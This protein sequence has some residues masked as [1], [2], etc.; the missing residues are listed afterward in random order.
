MDKAAH[1]F[2][3]LAGI[4][5]VLGAYAIWGFIAYVAI[6][7][8]GI[9]GNAFGRL[10]PAGVVP[11][12]LL[13]LVLAISV[14]LAAGT[15]RRQIAASRRLTHRIQASTL[16]P[17]PEL[18]A[19]AEPT[20]LLGRVA[21]VDAGKPFSF[22]YGVLVPRVAISRG[23]LEI[24]STQELRATL[25]HE[26]YHVRNLDPF[27]ALT[28]RVL[29]EAFF[30]LPS[31]KALRARYEVA[32]ELAA[33]RCAEQGCGRRPLLGALLKA[34]EGPR[35]HESAVSASLGSS[36]LLAARL[37]HL[38][39][40]RMP[41]LPPVSYLSLAWSTL[42]A[43]A[44]LAV[45]LSAMIGLGGTSALV[46]AAAYELSATGISLDALCV[47]PLAAAAFSY[48]R[49]ARQASQPLSSIVPRV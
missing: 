2:F 15:L 20:G 36:E 37:S 18:Q 48:W 27:R 39:T 24:L 13:A 1:N 42:G 31:L 6:P 3:A 28:A 12:L 47:A 32:R 43:V 11:A 34:L 23:F 5:A 46:R 29:S 10:P 4:C 30:L 9:G 45:F 19:A 35:W 8:F 38:E 7:L 40:G 25:A 21:L 33:D 17:T 26:R 14:G 49:L 44:F 22:V 16:P 41:A